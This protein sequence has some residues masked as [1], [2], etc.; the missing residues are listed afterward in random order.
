MMTNNLAENA[1][2]E[3]IETDTLGVYRGVLTDDDYQWK[4]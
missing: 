4:F 2:N 1:R 3:R